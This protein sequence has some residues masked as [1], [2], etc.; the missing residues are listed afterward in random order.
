MEEGHAYNISHY[1]AGSNGST[2]AAAA[3]SYI[4]SYPDYIL[5]EYANLEV[6]AEVVTRTSYRYNS[7]FRVYELESV[8]VVVTVRK[9]FPIIIEVVDI[10]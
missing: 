4:G 1:I 5:V 10:D 3:A 8:P 9:G 2:G 6:K 7:S